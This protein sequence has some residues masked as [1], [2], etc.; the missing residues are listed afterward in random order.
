[1]NRSVFRTEKICFQQV[2]PNSVLDLFFVLPNSVLDLF[3]IGRREQLLRA[4]A[5]AIYTQT[6]LHAAAERQLTHIVT[7][8]HTIS[9]P[10]FRVGPRCRRAPPPATDSL[11]LPPHP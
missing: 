10:S 4:D 8:S 7:I 9:L 5:A 3:F 11:I 2:L 1:M 6:P